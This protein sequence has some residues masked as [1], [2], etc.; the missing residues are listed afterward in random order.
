MLV[1]EVEHR[2]SRAG[3]SRM[4]AKEVQ[5]HIKKSLK[6]LI[7]RTLMRDPVVEVIVMEI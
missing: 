6:T 5:T 2:L 7:Y 1:R 3:E 4:N